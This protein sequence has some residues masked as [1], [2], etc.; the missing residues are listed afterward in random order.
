M[1]GATSKQSKLF[2]DKYSPTEDLEQ[3]SQANEDDDDEEEEA[4]A[5]E[6]GLLDFGSKS[7]TPQQFNDSIGTSAVLSRPRSSS[8]S[9]PAKTVKRSFMCCTGNSVSLKI[10]VNFKPSISDLAD[11]AS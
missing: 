4:E 2:I 8:W 11:I 5:F 9:Y 1:G 7:M 3:E 10:A 6:E